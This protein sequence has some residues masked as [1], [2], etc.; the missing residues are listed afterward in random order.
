MDAVSRPNEHIVLEDHNSFSEEFDI[1]T[2][3]HSSYDVAV[4]GTRC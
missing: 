3:F 4:D 2:L 1:Q